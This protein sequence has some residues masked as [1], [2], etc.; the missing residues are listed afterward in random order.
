[1]LADLPDGRQ[2]LNSHANGH[3][4]LAA[5]DHR[6]ADLPKPGADHIIRHPETRFAC[7]H[8]RV[9]RRFELSS[10][11][12]MKEML[13]N[14]DV[15]NELYGDQHLMAEQ[16]TAARPNGA[17]RIGEVIERIIER[18]NLERPDSQLAWMPAPLTP[19]RA[20][21]S[22]LN[23][24]LPPFCRHVT[25]SDEDEPDD[26]CGYLAV[27]I[28]SFTTVTTSKRRTLSFSQ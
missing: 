2:N 17:D 14:S 12:E 13:P 5:E 25:S 28:W 18:D 3:R 24:Y 21:P 19:Q 23:A 4:D 15:D 10:A 7:R 26:Q 20:G 16:V 8:G 1:M 22:K 11:M 6:V 9:T 27:R